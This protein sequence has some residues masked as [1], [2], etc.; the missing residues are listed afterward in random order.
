MDEK[1]LKP[2]LVRSLLAIKGEARGMHFKSD[3]DYVLKLKGKEGLEKLEKELM[4]V[5]CPIDFNKIKNLAFYPAGWRAISL[6]AIKQTFDWGDE[7]IRRVCNFAVSASLI[8]RLYMRFF[9]SIPKLIEQVPK[10]WKEY[11]S[12]GELKVIEFNE[13]ERRVVVRI[14]NF[15]LHSVYCRCFEGY[16]EH[17]IKMV[18]GAKTVKCQEIK[19]V[20]NGDKFH[21]FLVKWQL[22]PTVSELSS[23]LEAKE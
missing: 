1:I 11:F 18:V 13:D 7:D 15:S 20:F 21:E 22:S 17:F 5:G 2:E 6:L 14:E 16:L 8:V 3:G 19:C 23:D 12:E 9:Y 10:M 4:A